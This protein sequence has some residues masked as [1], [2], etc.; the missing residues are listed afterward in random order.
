MVLVTGAV[1]LTGAS[2]GQ[3]T[4]RIWLNNVQCTVNDRVLMNCTANVGSNTCTHA[5]D[6]GVRCQSGMLLKSLLSLIIIYAWSNLAI[7]F[8]YFKTSVECVRY[9]C[10]KF[11]I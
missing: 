9:L 4:G 10:L 8:S 3:G 7:Q 1:A 6:A 5:Q 11:R 2:F